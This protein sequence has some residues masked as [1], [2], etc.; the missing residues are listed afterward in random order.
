MNV[1]RKKWYHHLLRP[2]LNWWGSTM[3]GNSSCY[4]CGDSWWWKKSHTIYTVKNRGMFP[5]CEECH[6]T[7]S[8]SQKHVA[9]AL[10]GSSWSRQMELRPEDT[11][12]LK[13]AHEKVNEE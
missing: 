9:I 10:L 11:E 3:E 7:A 5:Y 8:K 12:S 4:I 1:V 13:V 2:F 6:L